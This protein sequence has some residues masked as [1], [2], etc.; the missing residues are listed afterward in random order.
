MLFGSELRT[1]AYGRFCKIVEVAISFTKMLA[2]V[3]SV[4]M[5]EF[6]GVYGVLA[7]SSRKYTTT[8]NFHGRV[9]L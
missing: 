6:A 9:L 8:S 1:A 4:C 2:Q 3:I 5:A 7:P